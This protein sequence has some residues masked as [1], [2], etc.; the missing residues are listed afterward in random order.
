[1]KICSKCQERL[2]YDIAWDAFYCIN[3]NEWAEKGCGDLV[4]HFQCHL[5]PERPIKYHAEKYWENEKQSKMRLMQKLNR[6]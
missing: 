4:C 5:R 2:S 1:M 3:C 6:K